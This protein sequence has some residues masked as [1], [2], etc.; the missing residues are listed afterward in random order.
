MAKFSNVQMSKKASASSNWNYEGHY[1]DDVNEA[2]KKAISLF[3]S[4]KNAFYKKIT[5]K[6][7]GNSPAYDYH[8][9]SFK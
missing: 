1:G 9:Y 7:Q 6:K 2:R 5:Q 4:G 8:V 3:E